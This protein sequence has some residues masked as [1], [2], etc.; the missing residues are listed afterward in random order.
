MT[1][2][3]GCN[4]R[5]SNTGPHWDFMTIMKSPLRISTLL[6]QRSGSAKEFNTAE[7]RKCEG[8]QAS[9]TKCNNVS[10]ADVPRNDT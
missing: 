10:D 6:R 8:V 7:E 4:D 5:D 1:A 3:D 2:C 9:S